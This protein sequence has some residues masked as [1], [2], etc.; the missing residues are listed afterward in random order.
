MVFYAG[1]N[2]EH[3][4]LI[5]CLKDEKRKQQCWING[6]T[7]IQF[8]YGLSWMKK[9]ALFDFD[10]TIVNQDTGLAYVVF[11]LRRNPLRLLSALLVFPVALLFFSSR[12]TRYISNAIFLWIATVGQSNFKINNI[13]AEF[14][15]CYLSSKRVVVYQQAVEEINTYLNQGATLVIITG[16]FEQLV[17]DILVK[18]DLAQVF[19]LG[20]SEFRKFGGM[21]TDFHCFSSNKLK[22]LKTVYELKS[23]QKIV[24]YSDSAAD[25][26]MLSICDD[27]FII[28]P[29]KRS[30]DKIKQAFE[31]N[32]VVLN[33]Q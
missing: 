4:G 17:M 31:H 10:K 24:G 25:I 18:L 33:W 1:L 26:P 6:I 11:A 9:L 15:S 13:R 29:S 16:C 5:S 32:I 20:S 7:F 3:C 23:F 12:K 28:N 30:L 19:V 27:K 8:S 21:I 14:V 22:R 2:V